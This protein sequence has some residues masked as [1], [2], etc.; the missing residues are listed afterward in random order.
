MGNLHEQALAPDRGTVLTKAA[1]RAG[2]RLGLSGRVLAAILGTSEAQISRFRRGE[3][4]L[5]E[6]AKSFELAAMLVRVFR[7]LDAMTGGDE[8]M[9]RAWMQA[10]NLALDARPIDLVTRI[11]GLADVV[12]YL[13]ARRAPL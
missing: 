5:A 6:N 7:S 12:A 13:D 10:P 4:A 2:A 8:A 9:A 3:A 1:M 11:Q